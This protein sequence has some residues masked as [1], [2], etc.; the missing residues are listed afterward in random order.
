MTSP[1]TPTT[2]EASGAPETP[3]DP[4]ATVHTFA[5]RAR[6][7]ATE[8]GDTNTEAM[9][10]LLG[11]HG[12]APVGSRLTSHPDSGVQLAVTSTGFRVSFHAPDAPN[13]LGIL[14]L[15]AGTAYGV[16]EQVTVALHHYSAVIA[17]RDE[18]PARP[19]DITERSLQLFLDYARDAAH[20]TGTPMVGGNVG[21]SAA[22]RGNL[23]QLKKAGLVD[24]FPSDGDMFVQFTDAGVALAAQHGIT[25]QQ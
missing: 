21:R 7:L 16:A 11:Y 4:R 12:F 22:D 2:P 25:I 24:T 20:W 5:E 19:A 14:D 3:A 6:A 9:R 10:L 18:P 8:T 15:P 23:T 1:T 17:A 13:G